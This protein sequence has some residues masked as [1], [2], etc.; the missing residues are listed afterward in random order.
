MDRK[1]AWP[2]G[3]DGRRG[4]ERE[5]ETRGGKR[6]GEQTQRMHGC[7]RKNG[8][9]DRDAHE[10]KEDTAKHAPNVR[11]GP[12]GV[13]IR[14]LRRVPTKEATIGTK[15][16]NNVLFETQWRLKVRIWIKSENAVLC[17]R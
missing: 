13:F 6:I 7:P 15:S 3:R 14:N 8:E 12:F 17:D 11:N 9:V 16:E 10:E 4:R 2:Q 5:R 1:P